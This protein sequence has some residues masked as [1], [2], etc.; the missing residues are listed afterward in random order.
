VFEL[1]ASGRYSLLALSQELQHVQG[2]YISN[3]NLHKMLSNP[4]YIGHIVGGG[5]TYQE[6]YPSLIMPELYMQAQ[7][8]LDAH[9]RPKFGKQDIAV[10]GMLTCAHQTAQ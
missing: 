8:V 2:T 5:Q 7:W 4:F 3:A 9:N 6:T 1:Y 10:R